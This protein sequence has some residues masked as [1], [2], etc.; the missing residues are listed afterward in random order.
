MIQNDRTV[1]MA[2]FLVCGLAGCDGAK[3]G[4]LPTAPVVGQVTY[5]GEPLPRGQ[6]KFFPRQADGQGLRVAVGVLD[7]QGR[8]CLGTYGQ[9]DGA[10]VGDF[11]VAIES[12]E[13]LP[14]ELAR[15]ASELGPTTRQPKSLVPSRYADPNTSGLT[16]HVE[17]GN[18]VVDFTLMD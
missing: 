17:V 18:N 1:I 12:R 10:I 15:R 2:L 7:Q 14:I 16:A 11:L 4:Q 13:E 9:G 6:I 5:R 8:Y 3:N